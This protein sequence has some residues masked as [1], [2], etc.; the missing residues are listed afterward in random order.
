MTPYLKT[1]DAVTI[2]FLAAMFWH[3]CTV[4]GVFG[5]VP[6]GQED[7]MIRIFV[8]LGILI[9]VAFLAAYI[10]QIRQ[11]G[12]PLLPDEREEKIERVSEGIGTLTIYIGL[13]LLAWFAFAPLTP[14]QFVN[15]MLAVVTAAELIKLLIVLR[16]HR[17]EVG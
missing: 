13:L 3:F 5:S 15:G 7:M 1:S 17:A 6:V 16:L 10:I 11:G 9:V 8:I 14:T 4:F 12:A 2:G